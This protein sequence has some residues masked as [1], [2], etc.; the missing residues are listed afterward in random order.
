MEGLMRRLFLAS[1]VLVLLSA[2]AGCRQ[3]ERMERHEARE[4]RREAREQRR[5]AREQRREARQAGTP[6]ADTAAPASGDQPA[7]IAA[8]AS[9]GDQ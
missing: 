1:L 8:P 6:P 4:K 9:N 7:P 5:E 3:L 2:A